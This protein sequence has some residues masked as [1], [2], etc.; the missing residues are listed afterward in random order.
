MKIYVDPELCQAHG[1]CEFFS[2]TVFRLESDLLPEYD[3]NPD[4]AQRADVEE[5]IAACP[6]QAIRET[7]RRREQPATL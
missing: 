5:A 6:A 2:P 1:R 7:L 3:A 4:E